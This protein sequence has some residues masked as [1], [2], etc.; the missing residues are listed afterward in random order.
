MRSLT[1][2]LMAA[3]AG[4]T[5]T[6]PVDA[7][8]KG[9]SV[10]C[11]DTLEIG[12]EPARIANLKWFLS[13]PRAVVDGEEVPLTF[14]VDGTWQV[15][16]VALIDL[17][18]GTEDCAAQGSEPTNDRLIFDASS[19]R[20]LRDADALRLTLGVPFARNH[21]D[22]ATQPP[23]MN[24]PVMFWVWQSGYKFARIDLAVPQAPQPWNLHL[25]S[26]GCVSDGATQAPT[27]ECPRPNRANLTLSA[28]T[29][30]STLLLDLDQ[31]FEGSDITTNAPDS[32][33]G[34][35]ANPSDVGDCEAVFEAVGLDFATG[36]C[37]EGCTRQRAFHMDDGG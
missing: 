17:E 24:D 22:P 5:F 19:A 9:T 6:L 37:I 29:H 34:C 20:V 2:I 21:L 35:M 4:D 36:Q 23:P 18:D 16:D 1:L 30:Q 7:V 25:G 27:V 28:P 8:S 31:L 12:G 10:R 14:V 26:T 13:E 3:C 11:G 32:P 15:E 33:P